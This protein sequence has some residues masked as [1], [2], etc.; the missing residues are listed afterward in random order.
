MKISIILPTYNRAKLFLSRA[1]NSVVNQ[2]YKDWEL[3]I[4]DNSSIDNTKEL[5]NS[6]QNNKIH[7]INIKNEG[8]IAK[9]RNLGIAH[10]QGSFIAFLDSDDYWEIDK[11]KNCVNILRSNLDYDGICHAE[12]WIYPSKDK[13]IKKYGPKKYFSFIKLLTRGNSVS[14]SAMIIKKNCILAASSFSEDK[15]LITAEDYD[16][17]IKL[18]KN[19]INITFTDQALGYYQ[20]HDSSE[21]SNILRNTKAIAYVI[22]SHL[23]DNKKLLKISLANCWKNAGKQFYLN[24]SNYESYKAYLKSIRYDYIN[25]KVYFLLIT[26]LIPASL[27]KYFIQKKHG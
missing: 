8:N 13:I 6:Y 2:S 11:L 18:T 15:K 4:I 10:S 23:K 17:W 27:Y 14:L 19:N 25:I 16:L 22:E 9:S 7:L 20:I 26:T 1:I 12:Y 24:C 5:V 21:S 3:I